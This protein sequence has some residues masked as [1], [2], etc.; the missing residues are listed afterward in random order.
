MP[1]GPLTQAARIAWKDLRVELRSREIVYTMGFF[2]AVIVVVYSFSFPLHSDLVRAAT[3]GSLWVATGLAAT[4]AP[5]RAFGRA[6]ETDTMRALLPSPVPR[7]A[8]FFGKTI[9]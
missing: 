7:L 9:A 4:I 1:P 5:A 2:G 8:V 3:P 6:R